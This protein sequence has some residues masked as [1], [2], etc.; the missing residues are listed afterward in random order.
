M[1]DEAV[2]L[3]EEVRQW[4]RRCFEL[5]RRLAESV[6][7]EELRRCE[8]RCEELE[9]QALGRGQQTDGASRA[10]RLRRRERELLDAINAD[11]ESPYNDARRR[12][13]KSLR[14]RRKDAEEFYARN[15]R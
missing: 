2:R 3:K 11:P 1:S 4:Q 9:N 7:A 12:E 15:Q 5:E 13:L 8:R 6:P 10:E 14:Q